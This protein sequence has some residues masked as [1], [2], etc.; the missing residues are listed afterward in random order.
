MYSNVNDRCSIAKNSHLLIC[1][2]AIAIVAG[3]VGPSEQL[4][5]FDEEVSQILSSYTKDRINRTEE[6]FFETNCL[7]MYSLS[8]RLDAIC[9]TRKISRA[10]VLSSAKVE[11]F[12]NDKD[13]IV[14]L[15]KKCGFYVDGVMF[16]FDGKE[17]VQRVRRFRAQL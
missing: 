2:L 16:K 13:C 1:A 14:L 12:C 15:F 7:E 11:P 5:A 17:Y 10:A 4:P 8:L 9:Q 3:C 6:D